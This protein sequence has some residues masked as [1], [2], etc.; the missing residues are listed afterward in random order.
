MCVAVLSACS[1][2]PS[3]ADIKSAFERNILESEQAA[4][5]AMRALGGSGAVKPG[6]GGKVHE[7]K[8][9]GCK[10]GSDGASYNCTVEVDLEA[11]MVGRQKKT[12]SVVVVKDSQGWNITGAG[13]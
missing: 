6:S 13:R 7:V 4:A 9:I 11:M 5:Q 2:E 12:A 3:A 10:Q 1:G 8:K